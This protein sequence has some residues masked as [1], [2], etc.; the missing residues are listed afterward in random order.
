MVWLELRTQDVEYRSGWNFTE[1]IWAPVLTEKGNQWAYWNTVKEALEGDVVIHISEVA[2]ANH[3]VGFSTVA[4]DAVTTNDLPTDRIHK[5]GF[6]ASFY[7]APLQEFR[8]LE[9]SI[10]TADFFAQNDRALRDF[11]A[12]NKV[13]RKNKQLLFY[14]IQGRPV[15]GITTPNLQCQNGGYLTPLPQELE[16]LLGI[17]STPAPTRPAILPAVP[18]LSTITG[19]ITRQLSAR[20]GHQRFAKNV[21]DNFAHRCCYPSCKVEGQHFLISG[22]I[23]RWA[24]QLAYQGLTANGLCLCLMH[25]KAFESGLF[26]LNDHYEVVVMFQRLGDRQWLKDL[27]QDGQGYQIKDRHIDPSLEALRLHRERIGAAL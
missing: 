24:D 10:P 15:D 8:P 12:R 4:A 21:K 23:A 25:D 11:Y 3:F 18:A 22:H 19:E 9:P 13:A 5:W 2:G 20:V 16:G 7:K 17:T 26:T 6:S 1:S 14:T 27:L